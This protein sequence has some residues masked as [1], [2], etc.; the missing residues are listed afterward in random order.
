M[1]TPL[2]GTMIVD[3]PADPW[4]TAFAQYRQA[5]VDLDGDGVPDAVVQ[6][7]AD[8]RQRQM[9]ARRAM[10]GRD[11][12]LTTQEMA[13]LERR[14]T[15]SEQNNQAVERGVGELILG[16]PI[17]A[18]M[19]IGEAVQDPSIA[20]LTNAG[21]QSALA[22]FRPLTA[23]KVAG[24]GFAASAANDLMTEASASNPRRRQQVSD[25]AFAELPGLTPQQSAEY[26]SLMSKMQRGAFGSA[27]DRRATETRARELRSLSDDFS[28]MRTTTAQQEYDN[29]IRRAEGARDTILAERP[30]RFSETSVGALYDKLG[31]VA[32]GVIAAGMGGLTR[33]GLAATGV[34]NKL[35]NYGLPIGVGTLTGGVAA[36]YPLGHEL[37]FAPSANPERQAFE[38]YARELP[39]DHPRKQ[40]WQNY[41]RDLPSA[42]PSRKAASDEFYDPMKLAER[43]AFGAVEGA[44]GGLAGAEA[45]NIA[46]RPFRRRGISEADN[47]GSQNKTGADRGQREGPEQS[48]PPAPVDYRTYPSLPSSTRNAVQEAYIADRFL[49]G[50]N[51]PAA[52]GA[53]SI[54]NILLSQGVN[55]P[56]TTQRVQTTNALAGPL[57]DQFI[58]QHGRAPNR[59]EFASFFNSRTLAIPAVAVGGGAVNNLLASYSG[60]EPIY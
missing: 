29:A 14:R 35:A 39:P 38:A 17:R 41:A 7:P 13:N 52:E 5:L 20:T 46:L 21:V 50:G 22:A 45:V 12:T 36:N 23:A 10:A 3:Q 6:A 37:M 60:Q 54:R 32:P 1:A 11:P 47:K 27:A 18:G 33:A 28:R 25:V 53:S 59:Q 19:A 8:N 49:R 55:V 44:L 24:G 9:M 51:L 42:N 2:P 58:K 43:T 57:I 15:I 34:S 26:N 56:V 40:E 48:E 4:D 30:K 16:Q 31:I